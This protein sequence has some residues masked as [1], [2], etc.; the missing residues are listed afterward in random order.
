MNEILEI[1]KNLDKRSIKW[2]NYFEIYERY[3][4]K[5]VGQDPQVLEI[6]IAEGGSLELW[7]KYFRNG[8]IWGVDID[9][10]C[11]E[12]KYEQSNIRLIFGDQSNPDFWDWFMKDSPKFDVIVDDG[13]HINEHQVLSLLKLFPRLKEGGIYMI[14]DTHTSYWEQWGGALHKKDTCVEFS[15]GLVDLLH[16]QHVQA[17]APKALVD[18]FNNLKSVTYYNSVIVLEKDY[19][20]DAKWTENKKKP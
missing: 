18:I 13:S 6:G 11:L 17:E 7:S 2:D 1:Y 3:F 4:R 12:Y 5:F 9:Q 20:T 19:V 10:K 8:Q 14:E 15:K 16:K